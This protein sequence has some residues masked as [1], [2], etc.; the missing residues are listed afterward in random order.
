MEKLNN[1]IYDITGMVSEI[2]QRYIPEEDPDT[3]ALSMFG[4]FADIESLS[5]QNAIISTGELGNELFPARAKY[6]RNLLSHAVVNNV[7]NINAVPACITCVI[8]FFENDFN[9]YAKKDIFTLDKEIKF[10]IDD[11]EFHL[12][13]DI[14]VRRN[15]ITNNE[16]VYTAQY[17]IDR[18]NPLS[19]IT[20][21]YLNTPF[22]Q[23]YNGDTLICFYTQLRQVM[24]SVVHK[25]IITNNLIENKTAQF[26]FTN[27]LASF[28]VIA[29]DGDKTTY[30]TPVLEGS[31]ITQGIA[32]Y[33]YYSFLDATH[34]KLRFDSGSYVPRINTELDIELR[35]TYGEKGNLE[36]NHTMYPMV[37][38]EK[39]GYTNIPVVT[40]F[41]GKSEGGLDRISIKELRKVLPKESLARGSITCFKDVENHFSMYNTDDNRMIPYKKIDNQFER[42]YYIYM[43]LKDPLENVIPTNTFDL[44]IERRYFDTHDNRKYVLKPG[45]YITFDPKT[46]IGSVVKRDET[47][48]DGLD[49]IE[50]NDK[51]NFLYTVPFMM[52][53]NGDPLYVSYYLSIVN[54]IKYLDFTYI[55]MNS[56]LQFIAVSIRWSRG[57]I[58]E[59]NV[60]KLWFNLLENYKYPEE[61]IIYDENGEIVDYNI[62]AYIV[63]YNSDSSD[64]YRYIPATITENKDDNEGYLVEA[65]LTTTDIINDDNKVRVE[66]TY[67]P[68]TNVI[69]YGYFSNEL[70]AKIYICAKLK[71]GE[72]G[73]YDLD[74]IVPGLEGWTVTNMYTVDGGVALFSNYSGI[75]HS[76]ISDMSVENDY[77]TELAFKVTSVPCVRRSYLNTETNMSNFV[78]ELNY[79]KAYIDNALK[80]LDNNMSI[81][82]KFFCTYG[83]SRAY[84]IDREGLNNIERVNLTLNFA[85]RLVA[86]ADKTVKEFIID[87][88][89]NYI[90]DLNDITSLH[91]P[92]LITQITTEYREQIEYFE[93]LGFNDYGPGIQ[94][95]YHHEHEDVFITPEFLTVH[96][97][98]DLVPDI[99]IRLD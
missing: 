66:G 44:I 82:F 30:I 28:T 55:N 92:N 84:S 63:F 24:H 16:Y 4:A 31:G 20:N 47:N 65:K 54:D 89:K 33:C 46:N 21:V 19:N 69:D 13:Y 90:E 43:L 12:D 79:K 98:E 38:S 27:Q 50:T 2:E 42:S 48:S 23:Q 71:E 68:N 7:D 81:D 9:K 62:R 72:F 3:L 49:I 39:Y 88:I 59:P 10:Y 36:Y 8:G 78:S 91:I 77:T 95:L 32:T 5:I 94:H 87:E 58:T 56:L 75:I 34:I 51:T 93:F 45:C 6:E 37:S 15:Y 99:N 40:I 11:M 97:S 41:G 52:V 25:K 86:S 80:L 85:M 74:G 35:T 76:Q 1:D 57:Y 17:N 64:P 18:E 53:V 96:T 22:L 73:R 26:Q 60:Y 61:L 70:V 83:P 67:V 29:I 14:V